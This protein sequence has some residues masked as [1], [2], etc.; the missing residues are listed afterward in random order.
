M[1]NLLVLSDHAHCLQQDREQDDPGEGSFV[2]CFTVDFSQDVLMVLNCNGMVYRS[3]MNAFYSQDG[4]KLPPYICRAEE[5]AENDWF[6]LEYV[7]EISC[8]VGI[9]HTGTI[10]TL[11]NGEC[12]QQGVIEGGISAAQWSPDYGSILI[13]TNNDSLLS[14]T[15]SWDVLNEVPLEPKVENS[16]VCISWRGDGEYVA[17]YSVDKSDGIGR[18]RIFNRD[19]ELHA[20]S[21]QVGEG[22]A[23]DI[24][25]LVPAVAFAN[26]GGLVAVGQQKGG[27][28]KPYVCLLEKNGLKHGE[29]EIQCPP[30]E[31]WVIECLHWDLPSNLLAV[32]L[33]S[34]NAS[35]P[36]SLLRDKKGVVQLYYRNNYHWYCK[37]CWSGNSLKCMGFDKETMDKL[38]LSLNYENK[39]V[40]R[41]IELVWDIVQ[42]WS[43]DCTTAVIDGNQVLLTPV[44]W[45]TVPP[46]MSK[47]Q[48][49]MPSFVR[50][51]SFW[52]RPDYGCGFGGMVCLCESDRIC[53]CFS[54]DDKGQPSGQVNMVSVDVSKFI[55]TLETSE[56]GDKESGDVFTGLRSAIVVETKYSDNIELIVTATPLNYMEGNDALHIFTISRESWKVLSHSFQILQGVANRIVS[57]PNTDEKAVGIGVISKCMIDN[58]N[59]EV[60]KIS[61]ETKTGTITNGVDVEMSE[62]TRVGIFP[63]ICVSI[64]IAASSGQGNHKGVICFGLSI[65]NKLYVG[66]LLMK[67]GVNSFAL[68]AGMDMLMY[69]T[70]GTRPHLHFCSLEAISQLDPLM[71]ENNYLLPIECALPRPLERG[72]RLVATIQNNPKVV[73]QLPRGNIEAFEPRPLILIYA[74]RLLDANDFYNCL[75]L[76]RRQKV[77][78][79][80]VIDYNAQNFLDNIE[81]MVSSVIQK[82]NG[83]DL[84]GL[85]ISSLDDYDSTVTKYIIPGVAA[86]CYP[87]SFLKEGKINSVCTA[88]RNALSATLPHNS[89]ALN[90]LLCT[91][92]RQKPPLL[93]DALKIIRSESKDALQ[94]SKCTSTLKYLAFLANNE[95]IFNAALEDCDFL[96]ATSIARISQMDPKIYIPLIESFETIENYC[97]VNAIGAKLGEESREKICRIFNCFMR[98]KIHIHL[99]KFENGV[100]WCL[101]ALKLSYEFVATAH[102]ESEA[103][104]RVNLLQV[105]EFRNVQNDLFLLI[106]DNDI[107]ISILPLLRGILINLKLLSGN[108]D[109]MD[110][111]KTYGDLLVG[112]YSKLQVAYGRKCCS[113]LKYDEAIASFLSTYP[114]SAEE[115]VNA[116]RM[117]NDWKTAIAIA[118]RYADR[119]SEL[120]P[121]TLVQ[122]LISDYRET[123]EQAEYDEGDDGCGN[124]PYPS[125]Q[126]DPLQSWQVSEE[127]DFPMEASK[128]CLSYL[129]DTDGAVSILLMSHKWI[130]AINLAINRNRFDL[131]SDDIYT[132]TTDA[133]K[134]LSKQI[135]K[136]GKLHLEL[137]TELS[138]NVWKDR[139][140][141]LQNVSTTEVTLAAILNGESEKTENVD[142]Q[143][144]EFTADTRYSQSS[145]VSNLSSQLSNSMMSAQSNA[146][147][148]STVS[149]LSHNTTSVCNTEDGDFSIKGL[150][151]G[152]LSR[153]TGD[154]S[155]KNVTLGGKKEK[156]EKKQRHRNSNRQQRGEGR[157]EGKDV[158]GLRNELNVCDK[159]LQLVNVRGVSRAVERLAQALLVLS[160]NNVSNAND[161]ALLASQLQEAMDEYVSILESKFCSIA[162]SYPFEWL[163]K[164]NM[165]VI[166]HFQS[167]ED[168]KDVNILL[169][170]QLIENGIETW[171]RTTRRVALSAVSNM[172]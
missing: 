22:A 155:R 5:T 132:A 41:V 82:N 67:S 123:L 71:F 117:N 167:P 4:S 110:G 43:T 160:E 98:Y 112:L 15:S 32:T 74:C 135:M 35:S 118:G 134:Q 146:S 65:K 99:K 150:D 72:A 48:V 90:P 156:K 170:N 2:S 93:I 111:K 56:S 102:L 17:V 101:Q 40:L 83:S 42:S 148:L 13:A 163:K 124:F 141:R 73:I 92:A 161:C 162:P 9:S 3:S 142:D 66:E 128:L 130:E 61:L 137:V 136:R 131:L 153:G 52:N 30:G 144:S 88:L 145:F 19:L 77:D 44:A 29:I 7:D 119:N 158:W 70:V 95:Q 129:D 107:F 85:L 105:D 171:K 27:K 49:T 120:N 149:I 121:K 38:Y 159:L 80:F 18:V 39:Q 154:G 133:A 152:L 143:G 68:N 106:R 6:S 20:I 64:V 122:E 94:S 46:P 50:Y 14:M 23:A 113:T 96:M 116:A 166:R 140:L 103:Q 63:E 55:K 81:S 151:H 47:Y 75:I 62:D 54:E 138:E 169:F 60:Y 84:L 91:L 28:N 51:I 21:R 59:Y 34:V 57:W 36:P 79:N 25:G 58:Y 45:A 108:F 115:A 125:L 12:E 69:V 109:D 10:C 86:R 53:I 37:Q 139:E 8:P 172:K 78:L 97:N 16:S 76:L 100:I 104:D 165:T 11:E 157:S 164:R 126:I 147:G 31:G 26:N 33:T 114:P 87:E 89:A 168:V 127:V 24:K 1:R